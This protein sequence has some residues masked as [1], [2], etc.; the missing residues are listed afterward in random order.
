MGLYPFTIQNT[1]P[2]HIKLNYSLFCVVELNKTN[3]Q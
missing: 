1:H 2:E 3:V